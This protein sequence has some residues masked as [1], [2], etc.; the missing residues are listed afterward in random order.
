MAANLRPHLLENSKSS[1][2]RFFTFTHDISQ[3]PKGRATAQ[4]CAQATTL[5]A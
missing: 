1:M 2:E 3:G 5:T 4:A